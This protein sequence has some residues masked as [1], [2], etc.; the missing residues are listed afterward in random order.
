MAVKDWIPVAQ[1]IYD[2]LIADGNPK[3]E[4][5][6]K[7]SHK[8]LCEILNKHNITVTEDMNKPID[9]YGREEPV[10]LLVGVIETTVQNKDLSKSLRNNLLFRSYLTD[11]EER[12]IKS[13]SN[14]PKTMWTY[15]IA[16]E[17]H[18]A[19]KDPIEF[20]EDD[21]EETI[22][23]EI[24]VS[25]ENFNEDV[26]ATPSK[27][28]K[29]D[30][31]VEICSKIIEIRRNLGVVSI[32]DLSEIL[33]K[34]FFSY[35][36]SLFA[37]P[38]DKRYIEVLEIL[39][40][41]SSIVN[42]ISTEL[43]LEKWVALVE[44]QF[45]KLDEIAKS[46]KNSNKDA[47][48]KQLFSALEYLGSIKANG[49]RIGL[50]EILKAFVV[51]KIIDNESERIFLSGTAITQMSQLMSLINAANFNIKDKIQVDICKQLL[52]TIK[53]AVLLNKTANKFGCFITGAGK[54]FPP[55][56]MPGI[57][58]MI[59]QKAA[60]FDK[61]VEALRPVFIEL[62]TRKPLM[63]GFGSPLNGWGNLSF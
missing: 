35:D 15:Q 29:H 28:T 3:Q 16:H 54:P 44:Y 43:S 13:S 59:Y 56:P 2:V 47:E 36:K 12:F 30:K 18:L 9:L 45:D 46:F 57:D 25:E 58:P 39:N 14:V 7:I 40:H 55:P 42:A 33:G 1:D 5:K 17:L 41:I 63:Q 37:I 23:D 38:G 24:E 11:A 50:D 6:L 34:E 26:K 21:S 19:F 20:L 51:G 53:Q 48:D 32:S 61:I 10:P 60:A 49:N 8:T 22:E 52:S 4:L 62:E 27:S 31:Y